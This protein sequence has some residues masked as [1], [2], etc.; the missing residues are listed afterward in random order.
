MWS[1]PS[2]RRLASH[3]RDQVMARE[4]GVVRARRPSASGPWSRAAA[5]RAGR[6][7]ASPTISS[8][9]AVGIDVGGV[10]QVDAR[11]ERQVELPARAL[12]VGGADAR[13]RP[14]APEG[15]GA[16][17]EDGDAEAGGPQL[18]MLDGWHRSMLTNAPWTL[19]YA[20]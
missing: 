11:V 17:G 4:A 6:A 13:E 18:A 7:I 14:A 16:Q 2:R 10:D 8:E 20:H 15:H 9:T 5:G 19:A 12:G 1:V 3:A